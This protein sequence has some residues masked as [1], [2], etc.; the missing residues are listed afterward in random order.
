MSR[1]QPVGMTIAVILFLAAALSGCAG[2]RQSP[3]V[4]DPAAAE[5]SS[6]PPATSRAPDLYHLRMPFGAGV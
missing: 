4:F 1:Y 6:T 2:D 3:S 5:G